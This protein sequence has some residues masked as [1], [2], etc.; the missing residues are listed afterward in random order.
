V[1][2][3]NLLKPAQKALAKGR[4]SLHLG[5][6]AHH[7]CQ[8]CKESGLVADYAAREFIQQLDKAQNG[9]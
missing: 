9:I 4:Q 8:Q 1:I 7:W 6:P 5:A 3:L 2:A